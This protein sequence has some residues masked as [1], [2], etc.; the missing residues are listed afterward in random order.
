MTS[1][2]KETKD[3]VNGCREINPTHLVK[4]RMK[5]VNGKRNIVRKVLKWDL[6]KWIMMK[7]NEKKRKE[8][9]NVI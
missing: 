6:I 5:E 3:K 2:Q 4:V 7:A 9:N 8:N 1:L